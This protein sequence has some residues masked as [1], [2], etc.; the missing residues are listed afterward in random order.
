MECDVCAKKPS[1][2]RPFACPTCAR[3]NLYPLRTQLA[4]VLRDKE[5]LARR[6]EAAVSSSPDLAATKDIKPLVLDG[7]VLDARDCA[8]TQ[9]L[10]ALQSLRVRAR[11]PRAR[12]PRPIRTTTRP[13]D[14][15]AG[16]RGGAAPGRRPAEGRSRAGQ[17]RGGGEEEGGGGGGWRRSTPRRRGRGGRARRCTRRRRAGGPRWCAAAARLAGLRR[18]RGAPPASAG[19]RRRPR[20]QRPALLEG[21]AAGQATAASAADAAGR[22]QEKTERY[23]IAAGLPVWDLRDLNGAPPQQLTASLGAVTQ[24]LLRAAGYLAVR[25]PAEIVPPRAA[26]ARATAAA[27]PAPTC[28]RR[29]CRPR[30]RTSASRPRRSRTGRPARAEGRQV[31]AARRPRRRS[32]RRRRL[33]DRH[34]RGRSRRNTTRTNPPSHRLRTQNPQQQQQSQ[35][36]S[37]HHAARPRP[38]AISK[39][40]PRLR[41]DDP[42]AFA[43]FVEA[44]SLLAWDAAWLATA[45]G[46][47]RRFDRWTDACALGAALH[48]ALLPSPAA[49]TQLGAYSHGS[50]LSFLGRRRRPRARRRRR[51]QRRRGAAAG[52]DVRRALREWRLAS[53]T[54]L[55]DR[56]KA[57]LVADAAGA[58]WEQVG[59]PPAA[60]AGGARCRR[61]RG[62]RGGFSAGTAA[63]GTTTTRKG[64]ACSSPPAARRRTAGARR[65]RRRAS[66]WSCGGRGTGGDGG[67]PSSPPWT[68]L[69]CR[70]NNSFTMIHSYLIYVNTYQEGYRDTLYTMAVIR[71]GWSFLRSI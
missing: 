63:T 40:L 42:A 57:Y 16:R 67:R 26:A 38:L 35:Q 59:L 5:D 31:R 46:A 68:R 7:A 51:R 21:E 4:A 45:A 65:G 33:C 64:A 13:D 6:I 60:G 25:L 18:V 53:P 1:P 24:L 37:R 61:E 19:R 17:A 66:C 52:K 14:A 27:A 43:R 9:R 44:A 3:S 36:L 12:G 34:R 70:L 15:A 22:Q 11:P 41:R 49:A 30:R 28:T 62:G 55:L 29:S 69:A 56:V 32:R 58:E 47:A 10:A 2:K 48:A 54:R 50:A 8:Q 20:T 71:V 23:E 39:P